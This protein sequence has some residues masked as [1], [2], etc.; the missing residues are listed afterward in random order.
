M[1]IMFKDIFDTTIWLIF[2]PSDAWKMLR[3]KRTD[4]KEKILSGYVYPFIGLITVTT[5]LGILF[6]RK[7]FDIQIALKSSIYTLISVFGGFFLSSSLLNEIWRGRL[8]KRRKDITLCQHFV[9]Y[10]SSLMFSLHILLSLLPEFFFLRLFVLYTVYIVWE[11]SAAYMD[12]KASE[13]IKFV[14]TATAIIL[15]TPLLLE[16]I[17]GLLIPGLKL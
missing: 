12:V 15:L 6:T 16:L 10:S 9:A 14:S 17:L 4:D 13:Q 1:E 11:G 5:F 7:E 3:K 2:K 8:F